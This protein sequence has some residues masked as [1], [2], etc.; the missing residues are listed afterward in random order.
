M[1]KADSLVDK[2]FSCPRI[3]L[4]NSQTLILDGVETGNSK[5]DFAT[6]LRRK[7][8]EV[9]DV[10][11]T[12]L[13]TAGISPT[14]GSVRNLAKAS[15]LSGSKVRQFLH[16]KPSYKKF[17]LATRKLKRMNAF[18]RFIN[19]LWCMELAYVDKIAKDNNG[20]N[21]LL[22][23]Q[24]LFDRTVN[25]KRMKTKVSKETVRAFLS[26]I[27]KKNRPKKFGLTKEQNLLQSFKTE[28]GVDG[29][30]I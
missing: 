10:Y 7:N 9:P 8:A 26:M 21:Y 19:E 16:W 23:R 22:L 1:S 6:Q 3:K 30:Q 24:D 28:G 20:L 25:A 12:L 14:F 13:D 18:D 29:I 27:T 11:F 15:N 5:L 17:T 4:S 2:I